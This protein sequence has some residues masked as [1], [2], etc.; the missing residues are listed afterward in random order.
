MRR[1]DNLTSIIPNMLLGP[2]PML[3]DPH[4]YADDG[5][6]LY[7]REQLTVLLG[8]FVT[9]NGTTVNDNSELND[10]IAALHS[11][12]DGSVRQCGD[13]LAKIRDSLYGTPGQVSFDRPLTASPQEVSNRMDRR[14]ERAWLDA[15]ENHLVSRDAAQDIWNAALRATD[16]VRFSKL[17]NPESVNFTEKQALAVMQQPLKETT[18]GNILC[19]EVSAQDASTAITVGVN[20]ALLST[21]QR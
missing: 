1:V 15:T 3:P 5:Q 12:E 8:K 11:C 9:Q 14:F 6:E 2:Y 4:S 7:T 10:I 18:I 13:K 20:A 16:D 21:P 17:P 19:K